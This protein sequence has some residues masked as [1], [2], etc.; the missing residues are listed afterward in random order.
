[1]TDN[2]T[3]NDVWKLYEDEM[4]KMNLAELEKRMREITNPKFMD[5]YLF[6]K[7]KVDIKEAMEL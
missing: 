6:G 2:L 3:K 5:L 7:L 1:M 4:M